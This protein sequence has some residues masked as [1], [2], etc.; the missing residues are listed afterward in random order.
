MICL[1]LIKMGFYSF[2]YGVL[3]CLERT[4]FNFGVSVF[5]MGL[6]EFTGHSS[7]SIFISIC[8]CIHTKIKKKISASRH[9]YTGLHN[10]TGIHHKN[11]V[12]IPTASK[13][14]TLSMRFFAFMQLLSIDL[15]VDL[16]FLIYHTIDGSGYRVRSVIY[17]QVRSTFHDRVFELERYASHYCYICYNGLHWNIAHS[18]F[19]VDIR[20]Q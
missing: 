12:T 16:I 18:I 5:L 8:S 4:G 7:G 1:I 17:G 13:F 19:V 2:Y 10:R 14:H 6:G 15:S 3:G 20:I 11:R 9:K